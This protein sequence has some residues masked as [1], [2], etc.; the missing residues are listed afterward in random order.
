MNKADVELLLKKFESSK[1]LYNTSQ[2]SP[3]YNIFEGL[4]GYI[5]I[6]ERE[7]LLRVVL[8]PS[9]PLEL[10]LIFLGDYKSQEQVLP[11]VASFEQVCFQEDE[12]IILD[13][14]R[15]LDLIEWS[16]DRAVEVVRAGLR[17]ENLHD[18]VEEF[19]VYW[20]YLE[21]EVI[22]NFFDPTA[23]SRELLLMHNTKDKVKCIA[24][25]NQ[26]VT[27]FWRLKQVWD[28][29]VVY[30]ATYVV[31]PSSTV[32]T[33]PLN[34]SFWSVEELQVIAES[35]LEAMTGKQRRSLFENKKSKNGYILFALPRS[36]SGYS[37][38]GI[39]YQSENGSHPLAISGKD[40]PI[41]MKPFNIKHCEKS[42]LVPRGGGRKDLSSKKVLLIGCGSV[43]GHVAHELVRSGVLNLTL[44][45]N[46]KLALENTFRH[47]LGKS[48]F[49]KNKAIALEEELSQKY[50][51]V[52]VSSIDTKAEEAISEHKINLQDYDL[53]IV[54]IG[55]P[56]VELWLNE[57]LFLIERKVPAVFTWLE[58]LGIGGHA[59]VVSPSHKGCFKCLYTTENGD[60]HLVNRASFA[61]PGQNFSLSLTG[62]NNLFTPYGSL[63]ASRTA[64]LAVK[65]AIKVLDNKLDS[66]ELSS[67]KGEADDFLLQGFQLS[68][69]YSLSE[70]S[71]KIQRRLFAHQNCP[72]C[73]TLNVQKRQTGADVTN[74]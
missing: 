2:L 30:T 10:P 68:D 48:K 46:D 4:E 40:A 44:V 41:R 74:F 65:A 73:G 16:I 70:E 49:G 7:V 58:P 45:D 34:R 15:P 36:S 17:K 6:E 12:G 39:Q 11:H 23:Q 38:F 33:P 37:L 50:P 56:T 14:N 67:W 20:G 35:A 32:V 9:F 28:K 63:D 27:D 55:S 61:A 64:G 8:P 69:R 13:S 59:L 60:F 22:M 31:L 47:V 26:Y 51:Y 19:E 57:Q 62:C 1:L 43:G 21:G 29:T 54:A 3:P 5:V 42:Y 52:K 53:M 71:L 66:S 18:F 72:T 24:E 25:S